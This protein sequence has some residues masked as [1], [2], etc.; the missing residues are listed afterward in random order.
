MFGWRLIT[1]P[2]T[3]LLTVIV[4][5]IAWVLIVYRDIPMSELEKKYGGDNVLRHEVDG[6]SLAYKVEGQGPAIVLIH[7]HYWT[8]RFWQT[9][10]DQLKQNYTVIR[11]DLTSHGL[12]GPDPTRDYSR[13]RASQLLESLLQHIGVDKVSLVGSSTGGAIAFYYAA[14]RPDQVRDL[15]MIN[16][17]GMPRLSNQYMERGLPWWGGYVFYLLP[18][19]IFRAFL[20]APVIDDSLITDDV[21]TEFHEM[22]RG[23]GN[24]M[25][26]FHRMRG[27]EKTDPAPLL[28]NIRVPTL[29]M[30]GEKNPQLPVDS[31]ELFEQRLVNA[32]RV[33]KI[34]Y[35][36]VGHVIPFEIPQQSV[37]DTERFLQANLAQGTLEQDNLN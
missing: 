11:Y 5:Y 6:V 24:R 8:M 35:P 31:V 28:K 2:L 19:N 27:W 16:T 7:S 15:V 9:W 18:K 29:I 3:L 13:K 23:S 10:V 26:E 33:E 21:L 1:V 4:L 36:D 12:T 22:Y 32:E 20:Q 25:A 17:P 30:W 37:A 34:V 14:T